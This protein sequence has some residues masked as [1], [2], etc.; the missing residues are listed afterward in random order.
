MVSELVVEEVPG[1]YALQPDCE[2][3]QLEWGP[4][5]WNVLELNELVSLH[6]G[7]HVLAKNCNTLGIGAPYIT[8][9]ADYSDGV[10]RVTKFTTKPT[11]MCAHGDVL[12]TVKGSGAGSLILSDGV[13]CIS[14]QLMAVRAASLDSGFLFYSLQMSAV[15]LADT[16]TGLIPGLSRS[17]LLTLRV[18]VPNTKSE[19]TAIANALSDV[20]ALITSLEKLIAK[21]R[22]IKT[23]TMQQL[24][25]GKTRLPPFDQQHTGYKQTE[26]GEIPADWEVVEL[27]SLVSELR[28]GVS[29]NSSTDSSAGA[30]STIR[31]LKTSCISGGKFYPSE[32]KTIIREDAARASTTPE[33]DTILISRMNTQALVGEVGYIDRDY[34]NYFLP[35]RLWRMKL[36]RDLPI[37]P[38]WVAT[39]LNDQRY[40]TIIKESATGT[41]GSMKNISKRSLLNVC[42][43]IPDYSEQLAL[44]SCIRD[45]AIE[46]DRC[47]E[48]LI[49]VRHIKNAMMQELLTGRTRLV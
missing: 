21:K 36:H 41:S 26:S 12:I 45:I 4:T 20:D 30:E 46:I 24:L 32:S 31:I 10:L 9:P 14:R 23:A 2:E 7:H 35:D 8:G 18:A 3:T 11:T 15:D 47:S 39:L 25:T 19:Q 17:D 33:R 38:E 49:K 37:S 42:I 34:P 43:P 13:Y 22:A 16:A 6:S 44:V 5:D 28:A 40:S 1:I 29:V 48:Q 27:K